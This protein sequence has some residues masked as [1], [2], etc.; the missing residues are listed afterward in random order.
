M[1]VFGSVLNQKMKIH[2][3]SNKLTAYGFKNWRFE[4]GFIIISQ[5]LDRLYVGDSTYHRE[6]LA[7][8]GIT[9]II[10]VGGVDLPYNQL[11]FI[12]HLKDD[13]TNEKWKFTTILD[14]MSRVLTHS[15]SRKLLV[16]CRAGI[17]RSCFIILLW[18]VKTGMSRDEAYKFIKEK[19][20]AAQINID[21]MES[22]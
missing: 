5:I 4:G 19:H 17:S 10:N 7:K 14:R 21:L 15:Y 22:Y 12:Q 9:D 2:F 6:D 20:P 3:I 13:G 18:L 11:L 8:L 1:K 16:C